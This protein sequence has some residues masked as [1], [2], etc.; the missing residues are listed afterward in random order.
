[1]DFLENDSGT[2]PITE[3]LALIT[4]PI[5]ASIQSPMPALVERNVLIQMQKKPGECNVLQTYH[6]FVSDD[7][8]SP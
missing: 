8:N 7:A 6:C 1:M 3:V 5:A 2:N 4:E